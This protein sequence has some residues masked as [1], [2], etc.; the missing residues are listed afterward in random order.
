MNHQHVSPITGR[1]R[2]RLA[3]ALLVFLAVA[4]LFLFREHQS[5]VLRLLPYLLLLAC[6]VVHLFMHRGHGGGRHH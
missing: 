6:P 1:R 5:H 2:S 4:G 3:V